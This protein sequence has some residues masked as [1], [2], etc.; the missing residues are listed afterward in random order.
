MGRLVASQGRLQGF[1]SLDA[2]VDLSQQRL[3]D[4][5]PRIE[6]GFQF[7]LQVEHGGLPALGFDRGTSERNGRFLIVADRLNRSIGDFG[8]LID[9]AA[10]FDGATGQHPTQHYEAGDEQKLGLLHRRNALGQRGDSGGVKAEVGHESRFL[11]ENAYRF[12]RPSLA[13][14]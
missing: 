1:Q 3:N 13:A 2:L 9:S 11:G 10:R 7:P 6:I 8:V 14:N 4:H 5:N 12:I